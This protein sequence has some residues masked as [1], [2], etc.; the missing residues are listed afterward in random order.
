MVPTSLAAKSCRSTRHPG[1]RDAGE[2]IRD[3]QQGSSHAADPGSARSRVLRDR[4][5]GMTGGCIGSAISD[6][7]RQSPGSFSRTRLMGTVSALALTLAAGAWLLAAPAAAECG[8][9]AAVV[10]CSGDVPNGVVFSPDAVDLTINVLAGTTITNANGSGIQVPGAQGCHW[11]HR[12]Q[13]GRHPAR[14]AG[15][16]GVLARPRHNTCSE[17]GRLGRGQR[18]RRCQDHQRHCWRPT[19]GLRRDQHRYGRRADRDQQRRAARRRPPRHP[20]PERAR[21]DRHHDR[22]DER[23]RC[24]QQWHLCR[25]PVMATSPS[26]AAGRINA[27]HLRHPGPGPSATSW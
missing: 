26:A 10:E 6:A 21:H 9:L 19:H 20:C 1:S 11:R 18:R 14:H 8:P 4:L 17:G 22:C 16:N 15:H 2:A 3:L 13:S 7:P 24:Q 25:Q 5:A 12:R 23:D 27:G